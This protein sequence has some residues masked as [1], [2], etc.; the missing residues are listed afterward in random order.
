MG[1]GS[2]NFLGQFL[3]EILSVLT[4]WH[5]NPI[6]Y[7]KESFLHGKEFMEFYKSKA[8]SITDHDRFKRL[9]SKWHNQLKTLFVFSLESKE[10]MHIRNSILVLD[11]IR[12]LFPATKNFATLIDQKV[13]ICEEETNRADLKQL[14]MSYRA[15]KYVYEISIVAS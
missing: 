15:K 12:G 1:A 8:P 3:S 6:L 5:K 9:M 2:F 11:K 10:F 13:Q 4:T 7:Q 14:A